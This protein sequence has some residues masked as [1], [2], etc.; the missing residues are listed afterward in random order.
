MA[1]DTILQD[2]ISAN[3]VVSETV[4][5]ENPIH[6]RKTC[7]RVAKRKLNNHD[8]PSSQSGG[9]IFCHICYSKER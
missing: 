6:C 7:C 1:E 8:I 9:G 3:E 4:R 2:G 5:M